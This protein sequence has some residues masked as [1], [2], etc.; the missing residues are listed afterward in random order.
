[1]RRAAL[2]LALVLAFASPAAAGN[3][4]TGDQTVAPVQEGDENNVTIDQGGGD[5]H[6]SGGLANVAVATG[7]VASPNVVAQDTNVLASEDQNQTVHSNQEIEQEDNSTSVDDSFNEETTTVVGGT[8]N[9]V[10]VS[11]V[12]G[13]R[14]VAGAGGSVVVV[15]RSSSRTVVP[16]EDTIVLRSKAQTEGALQF[17]LGKKTLPVTGMPDHFWPMFWSA[18]S[19]ISVGIW[20]DRFGRKG[21]VLALPA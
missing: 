3:I 1:M 5:A 16:A 13:T 14:N 19:L 7:P 20:L 8:G 18:V 12:G 6:T 17:E 21:R 2:A 11:T 4:N 9:R 15:P 10:D